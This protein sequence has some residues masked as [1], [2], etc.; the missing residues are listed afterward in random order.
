MQRREEESEEREV[1]ETFFCILDV[2]TFVMAGFRNFLM[3]LSILANDLP[4]RVWVH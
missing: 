1:P 4:L 3:Q 2:A